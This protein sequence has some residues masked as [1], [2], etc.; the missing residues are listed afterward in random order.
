MESIRKI[1]VGFQAISAWNSIFI[2]A[3]V[4]VGVRRRLIPLANS[5]V[6]SLGA[7]SACSAYVSLS[8]YVLSDAA[9]Q[10]LGGPRAEQA[11][12]APRLG[13]REFASSIGLRR[14]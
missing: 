6:P 11:L 1:W 13:A 9:E 8:L 5:R 3:A 7:P 2:A 10:A 4:Q 14:F 12:G